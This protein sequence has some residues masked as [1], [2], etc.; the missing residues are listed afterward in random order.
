MNPK[1]TLQTARH[2][3]VQKGWRSGGEIG[4]DGSVCIGRAIALAMG[5]PNTVGI[6]LV[7]EET[8]GMAELARSLGF[9]DISEMVTWN[10]STAKTQERILARIDRALLRDTPT[11]TKVPRRAM[12]LSDALSAAEKFLLKA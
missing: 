9:A 6:G 12:S 2:I 8:E 7:S 11:V 4:D 1:A 5:H 10:D 3:I